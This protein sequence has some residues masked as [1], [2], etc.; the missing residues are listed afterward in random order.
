M[1]KRKADAPPDDEETRSTPSS[2]DVVRRSH[3]FSALFATSAVH[4]F[5]D[6]FDPELRMSVEALRK[7]AAAAMPSRALKLRRVVKDPA[8]YVFDNFLTASECASV[9]AVADKGRFAR[10][11]TAYGREQ[12]QQ[13]DTDRTSSTAPLSDDARVATVIRA[14]VA[15]CLELPSFASVEHPPQIVQ[16]RPGQ[17]FGRHHDSGV[18]EEQ[19]GSRPPRVDLDEGGG[20]GAATRMFTFFLYVTDTAPGE[21]C[22]TFP[23]L[24]NDRTGEPVSIQPVAGRAV[25]FPNITRNSFKN[26]ERALCNKNI[27]SAPAELQ[28]KPLELDYRTIHEAEPITEKSGRKIGVNVWVVNQ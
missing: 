4:V 7:R 23:Y 21:G 19:R 10:S 11:R 26:A 13:V 14:K 2:Q 25:L 8:I 9:L 15:A 27:S 20:R 5:A 22:T 6:W 17:S 16:Y 3:R 24:K 18:L 28:G 12:R 1:A